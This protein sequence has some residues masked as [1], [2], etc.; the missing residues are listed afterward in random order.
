MTDE[1]LPVVLYS[2][3]EEGEYVGSRAVA[4][5]TKLFDKDHNFLLDSLSAVPP[6]DTNSEM[7]TG[8]TTHCEDDVS[9]NEDH[10]WNTY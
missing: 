4:V 1:I 7:R 2:Q 10:T 6:S 5:T 3:Y 8:P 9:K